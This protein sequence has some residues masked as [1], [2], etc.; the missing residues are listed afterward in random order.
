MYAND[1]KLAEHRVNQAAKERKE[2][3]LAEKARNT[4]TRWV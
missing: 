3:E 2:E 1:Q 4:P